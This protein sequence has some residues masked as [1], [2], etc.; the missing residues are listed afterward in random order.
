MKRCFSDVICW[1]SPPHP[2]P[3]IRWLLTAEKGPCEKCHNTKEA[4]KKTWTS[5]TYIHFRN[6]FRWTIRQLNFCSYFFYIT[7]QDRYMIEYC[8][9]FNPNNKYKCF[10]NG[11]KPWL[12]LCCV[13][14]RRRSP[15]ERR[16]DE[17]LLE[18]KHR[19]RSPSCRFVHWVVWVPLACRTI[20]CAAMVLHCAA[21]G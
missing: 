20:W 13:R 10:M 16:P 19:Q 8:Q 12:C 6:F 15:A 17:F 1:S 4:S 7:L 11:M 5:T 9:Q 3:Y 2:R 14:Y 18:H 21:P